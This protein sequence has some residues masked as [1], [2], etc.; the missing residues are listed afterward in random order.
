[1]LFRKTRSMKAGDRSLA[2]SAADT[3]QLVKQHNGYVCV[4]ARASQSF[5][6]RRAA[7]GLGHL[8]VLSSWLA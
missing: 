1:M 6:N 2:S 3:F 4:C 5:R 8:W 7:C